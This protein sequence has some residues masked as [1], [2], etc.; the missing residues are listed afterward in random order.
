[1]SGEGCQYFLP[2]FISRMPFRAITEW[3]LVLVFCLHGPFKGVGT[4]SSPKQF[5]LQG[6]QCFCLIAL[7]RS[8]H[9]AHTK[10][11]EL[12]G[13]YLLCSYIKSTNFHCL[14]GIWWQFSW[15]RMAEAG[16]IW[17]AQR[18]M[19]L[20]RCCHLTCA[21]VGFLCQRFFYYYYYYLEDLY[22][23]WLMNSINWPFLKFGLLS[24][25]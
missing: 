18:T 12:P 4:Q 2:F 9:R 21:C 1:M 23:Q 10:A 3:V 11:L 19:P 25:L 14:I 20:L 16:V 13:C 6:F 8:M 5:F 17:K 15:E 7:W 24:A 22:I